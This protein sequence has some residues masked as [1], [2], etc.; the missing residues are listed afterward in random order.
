MKVLK[1]ALSLFIVGLFVFTAFAVIQSGGTN[2]G[3]IHS[4][5]SPSSVL[6]YTT[7]SN[8]LTYT[9]ESNGTYL[10]NGHYLRDPPVAYPA[11]PTIA[12]DGLPYGAVGLVGAQGH[13][14]P[15]PFVKGSNN[16]FGV[17]PTTSNS[18]VSIDQNTLWANSTFQVYGNI[19]MAGPYTFTIYDSTVVFHEPASNSL[20]NYKFAVGNDG[21]IKIEAGSVIESTGDTTVSIG[22]TYI[23]GG[24]YSFVISNTTLNMTPYVGH[25]GSIDQLRYSTVNGNGSKYGLV[26]GQEGN[27]YGIWNSR[28]NNLGNI[29]STVLEN[30]TISNSQ[31]T[32]VPLGGSYNLTYDTFTNISLP[33][34]ASSNTD[35]WCWIA[36]PVTNI[37]INRDLFE[38]GNVSMLNIQTKSNGNITIENVTVKNV[39]AY[40]TTGQLGTLFGGDN[41]NNNIVARHLT[42]KN[43]TGRDIGG[44]ELGIVVTNPQGP[45]YTTNGSVEYSCINGY[46]ITGGGEIVPFTVSQMNYNIFNHFTSFYT[47]KVLWGTATPIGPWEAE[48]VNNGVIGN[49]SAKHSPPAQMIGNYFLNSSGGGNMLAQVITIGGIVENNTAVNLSNSVFIGIATSSGGRDT[50]VSNNYEYGL[51]NYSVG[52]GGVTFGEAVNTNYTSNQAFDVDTTS[53]PFSTQHSSE[54][55]HNLDGNFLLQNYNGSIGTTPFRTSRDLL[56]VS[57]T[58]DVTFVN[59]TVTQLV[60]YSSDAYTN[61]LSNGAWKNREIY[62]TDYNITIDNTY[63]PSVAYIFNGSS[64]MVGNPFDFF[65]FGHGTT[66][67]NKANSNPSFLNLTGYLGIYSGQTYTLNASNIKNEASLPIYYSGNEIADIPASSAHYN[68]TAISQS[69]YSVSTTSAA[70]PSVSLYFHGIPGLRYVVSIVSKG[71]LF[72]SFIEN[73]T[74]T[75]IVN[76]TYN[77]ATMPLDPTF[78]VSPYVAPPPPYN[79]V[80]PNPPMN[81]FPAYVFYILLAT[82]AAGVAA[83]IYILIR[84][85]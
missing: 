56:W 62:T 36:V 61:L 12:P 1:R 24:T 59:S 55:W 17:M 21:T 27:E 16:S 67:N 31:V 85:R 11:V 35:I 46:N 26:I 30:D 42:V 80:Q 54:T 51:Y 81:F 68:F 25:F 50:I 71:G 78:E 18:N 32:G 66:F 75:G 45:P 10:W 7:T 44:G 53:Y 5:S 38:N 82:S 72:K 28:L 49:N 8:G 15:Y 20:Y 57:N 63:M 3:S 6:P 34:F 29:Q 47:P 60:I 69:E 14:G 65:D 4:V 33:S 70:S 64:G 41:I 43:V 37:F 79:P 19:T 23:G 83:G 13:I 76:A 22:D 9:V 84:R 39:V 77:P 2:T 40:A 58:T 74:S 52:I 73:A 48:Q